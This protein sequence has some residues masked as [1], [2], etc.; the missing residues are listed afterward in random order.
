MPFIVHG[1]KVVPDSSAIVDYFFKNFD[2]REIANHAEVPELYALQKMIEESLYFAMLYNRWVDKDNTKVV[3]DTFAPLFP[4][5]LGKP[6]LKLIRFNLI[7]QAKAQGTGRHTKSEVYELAVRELNVLEAYLD[8]KRFLMGEQISSID[9]TAYAFLITI[10]KQEIPSPL[11]D[12]IAG[13]K[14]IISYLKIMNDRL[15][16]TTRPAPFTQI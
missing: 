6:A 10:L 7:K 14:P 9:C 11:Q 4:L 15:D 3:F 16:V 13:S 8:A 5:F 2:C 1:D 12:F